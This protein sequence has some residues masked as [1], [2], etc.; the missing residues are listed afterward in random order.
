VLVEVLS[1]MARKLLAQGKVSQ[2]SL[3][4]GR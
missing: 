1:L 2:Q 3:L 4:A